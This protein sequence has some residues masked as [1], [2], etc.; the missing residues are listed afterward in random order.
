MEGRGLKALVAPSMLSC[1]FGQLGRD[2]EK[3]KESG[4]DW[5]HMDVMDGHF[6]PNITIGAP[7][8][9]SL[10]KH[11][12]MFL[13]C[14]MMVT[15]PEKW[16]DDFA[17]AGASSY[18]FHIESTE[19][20]K[21]LIKKIKA[22]GMKVSIAVKPKTDLKQTIE[23]LKDE[24]VGKLIDMILI[25]TVEP[26]FGGQEFMSDMMQKVERL[27]HIFPDLNIQVDGGINEKTID[28]ATRAGA[29]VIVSGSGVFKSDDPSAAIQ[30][31]RDSVQH[32]IG[33]SNS[34]KTKREDSKFI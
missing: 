26:G 3:M 1:D 28:R 16:V 31:L 17:K 14:H 9:T 18:S 6:V 19:D 2:A 13:D 23:L 8:I 4:A 15:N 22:T 29:N 32:N 34:S 5:L 30:L 27:R 33:C 24:E 21:N 7:V 25:M 12:D 11:T 20:P 10:R